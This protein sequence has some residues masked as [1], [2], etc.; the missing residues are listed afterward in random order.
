MKRTDRSAAKTAARLGAL[1][2]SVALVVVGSVAPAWASTHA[3]H[4][5]A[6]RPARRSRPGP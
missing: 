1:G 6:R 3:R 5:R 4:R 2:S